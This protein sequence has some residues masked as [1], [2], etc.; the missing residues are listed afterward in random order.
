MGDCIVIETAEGHHV[1]NSIYR[2]LGSDTHVQLAEM[3]GVDL[4]ERV[5][6]G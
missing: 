3:I 4:A 6:N 1:F 5:R 2:A